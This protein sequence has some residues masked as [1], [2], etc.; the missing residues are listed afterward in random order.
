M[1]EQSLPKIEAL[2]QRHVQTRIEHKMST[3]CFSCICAR[4]RQQ[5]CADAITSKL[6]MDNQVVDK[7]EAPIQKVFLQPIADDPDNSVAMPRRRQTISMFALTHH[8]SNERAG[9]LHVRAQLHHDRVTCTD[10]RQL[11]D[12]SEFNIPAHGI[13]TFLGSSRGYAERN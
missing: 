7:D 3:A 5:S 8:L 6:L 1:G 2:G 12:T 4:H 13:S 9:I 10:F 11:L